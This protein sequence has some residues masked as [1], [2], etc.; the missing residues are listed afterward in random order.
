M[1]LGINKSS[2]FFFL[3]SNQVHQLTVK[4]AT[5]NDT[6]RYRCEA[7]NDQATD[8][9]S[10]DIRVAGNYFEQIL[11]LEMNELIHLLYFVCFRNFHS[12]KLP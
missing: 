7:S 11:E 1:F 8:S 6:G 9:N 5:K 12:S 2:Y 4:H 3:E 10:V